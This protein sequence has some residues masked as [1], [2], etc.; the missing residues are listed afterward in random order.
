MFDFVLFSF[1]VVIL[2]PVYVVRGV[3]TKNNLTLKLSQGK[4]RFF[5]EDDKYIRQV[6][7]W[8]LDSFPGC[9]F[10]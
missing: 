5:F 10:N 2:W 3:W 1:I 7:R 6:I 8:D 4:L 9:Y